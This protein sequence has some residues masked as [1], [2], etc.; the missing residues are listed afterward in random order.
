[1]IFFIR[2]NS[3]FTKVIDCKQIFYER[4]KYFTQVKTIKN[5]TLVLRVKKICIFAPL[6]NRGRVPQI[7]QKDYVSKN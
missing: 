1:M 2:Y 5:S 7:N 3:F 4:L 6:N